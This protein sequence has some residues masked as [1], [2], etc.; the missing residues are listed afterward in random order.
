MR[1]LLVFLAITGYMTPVFKKPYVGAL[2]WIW[3][4]VGTPHLESYGLAKTFQLNLVVAVV[5]LFCWLMYKKD[6]RVYKNSIMLAT[7]FLLFLMIL[8]NYSGEVP[9]YSTQWLIRSLK[10]L[11]L[12]VVIVGLV[13]NRIRIH[14]CMWVLAISLGY[15]GAKAGLGTIASGGAFRVSGPYGG[16]I[17]DNNHTAAALVM[18]IPV[19]NYLR[20]ESQSKL[21][22]ILVVLV[23]IACV[24]GVLGTYSRG[25]FIGLCAMMGFYWLRSKGK[26]RNALVV[27]ILASIGASFMPQSYYDR[28]ATIESADEDDGSFKG[29]LAAWQTAINIANARPFGAGFRAYERASVFGKY[30]PPDFHVPAMAIHSVYFEVLADMGYPGLLTYLAVCAIAWLNIVWLKQHTANIPHLMWA[31]NCARMIE[32]SF[33]GFAV[34]GAALSMSFFEPLWILIALVVATRGVV[35]RDLE[36]QKAAQRKARWPGQAQPVGSLAPAE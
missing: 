26:V 19:M 35:E 22:R 1:S 11:M 9:S 18:I 31:N 7:Y 17:G 6:S 13:D 28:L 14:A 34:A 24:F 36:R 33:A 23:T 21:V 4:A 16:P 29:R 3:I 27:I 10:V 32:I 25:G 15:Y 20:L 12:A 2:V 8:S 5:T 30:K